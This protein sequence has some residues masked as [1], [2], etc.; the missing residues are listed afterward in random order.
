MTDTAITELTPLVGVTAACA[1]VGRPRATHYR[2]HR[3]NPPPAPTRREPRP[4]PRALSAAEREQVLDV[5]HADR[6][7][8]LSPG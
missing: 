1:A 4:Q 2:W 8:D 3:T 6:F 5:L 7:V